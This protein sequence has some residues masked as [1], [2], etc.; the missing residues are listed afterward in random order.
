MAISTKARLAWLILCSLG[1]TWGI[2]SAFGYRDLGDFGSFYESGHAALRGLNPYAV[3][4]LTGSV[5]VPGYFHL[6]NPNLD[7]PI[8]VVLVTLFG[9]VNPLVGVTLWKLLNCLLY[10]LIVVLL[11]RAYPEHR[12]GPAVGLAL[13][14]APFWDAVGEGNIYV[15]LAAL[16]VGTWLALR[17]KSWTTAGLFLGI[18]VAIKPPVLVWIALLF[19]A[20]QRRPAVVAMALATALSAL[21]LLLFGPIIY[22]QWLAAVKAEPDRLL[23]PTNLSLVSVFAQLG[24]PELGAL[25]AVLLLAGVAFWAWR[26][27]PAALDVSVVAL[28]VMIL[29]SPIAWYTYTLYLLPL[30]F[31]RRWSPSLALAGLCLI[32]P[33]ALAQHLWV[34][35][36]DHVI[37]LGLP[38]IVS[39]PLI[40]YSHARVSISAQARP[41]AAAVRSAAKLEEAR[42]LTTTGSK[43]RHG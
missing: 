27:R 43:W 3:Y 9:L 1:L 11:L 14:F 33:V 37:A 8:S 23:V 19:L 29:A 24:V 42:A 35:L 40:L 2:I 41:N 26:C 36:P 39:L 13:G 28:V 6:A 31:R 22:E 5:D 30:F 32:V 18:L 12:H 7:P 4:P 15:P 20:G 10:G 17:A 38:W 34:W 16:V 21:P 25:L